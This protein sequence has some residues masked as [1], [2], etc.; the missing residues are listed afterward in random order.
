MTQPAT[1]QPR[2]GD[3]SP[4]PQSS[5]AE[6]TP[7]TGPARWL[8]IVAVVAVTAFVAG[9]LAG[10]RDDGATGQASAI[11]G[12][13][14]SREHADAAWSPL[15]VMSIVDPR[16]H[17]AI[18]DGSVD[19]RAAI[20]E[21]IAALPDEGGVVHLDQGLRFAFDG[22]L[23]IDR[24]HVKLWSPD[25]QAEVLQRGGDRDTAIVCAG[26]DWCG[27]FGLRL[28]AE[29]TERRYALEDSQ[30]AIVGSDD[31]EIVGN[32]ISGGSSAGVFFF[33]A[34][35]GAYVAGNFIHRTWADSVH[36]TDGS[37]GAW[38]WDNVF[39]GEEP[40]RGDDGIACVTYGDTQPCGDMEWW[41]N[42]HLGSGWGRG[43]AVVGGDHIRIHHNVARDTAAAGILVASEDSYDTPGSSDISI[44][45]N[46]LIGTGQV[47]PHPAILIS[48]LNGGTVIERVTVENNTIIDPASGQDFR[49]EGEV[50][51]I[52]HDEGDPDAVLPD[53]LSSIATEPGAGSTG[54][55]ATRDSS[56]WVTANDAASTASRSVGRQMATASSNASST[57][58]PAPSRTSTTG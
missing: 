15:S 30:I 10:R 3:P 21:A 34:S 54:V 56:F 46:V 43:D 27:L 8:V 57:S 33:D 1:D 5:V 9:S 23:R 36:F 44:H 38:V 7:P 25:G 28:R 55:L 17:G 49:T 26:V 42:V 12:A 14:P 20:E 35:R 51:D 31:T 53:P 18:G 11:D 58:S 19:D 29:A 13:E 22:V 2:L 39:Y 32:D 48:A 52:V 50:V 40:Q 16:D 37:R 47:V 41:G 4:P 24:D 45:D 6:P